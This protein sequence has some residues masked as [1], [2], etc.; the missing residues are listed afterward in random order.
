MEFL[1]FTLVDYPETLACSLY[2]PGCPLRCSY[3]HNRDL[4]AYRPL[5]W[6]YFESV[7]LPKIRAQR[8][9]LEALVLSGGEPSSLGAALSHILERL[10]HEFPG[11]KLGMHSAGCSP[12]LILEQFHSGRLD[13]LGLD[14]KAPL[15]SVQSHHLYHRLVN[16]QGLAQRLSFLLQELY[17]LAGSI[18]VEIRL[19]L[20]TSVWSPL[21]IEQE[22]QALVASGF[23]PANGF[24]IALQKLRPTELYPATEAGKD[25]ALFR[26]LPRYRAIA[27]KLIVRD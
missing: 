27:P 18:E 22:L 20:T 21:S 15:L 1:G 10:R 12:G 19:S 3:C 9:M 24:S 25:A 7:V 2:L 4:Q 14:L 6:D 8:R 11:L 17:H 16:D 13:W 26:A 5:D 23:V